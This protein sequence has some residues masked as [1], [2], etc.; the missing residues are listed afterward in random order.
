M[1]GEDKKDLMYMQARKEVL[2][3]ALEW[4]NTRASTFTADRAYAEM[5]LQR[6]VEAY[7]AHGGRG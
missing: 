3:A 2:R 5:R 4:G 7:K 6:A 1:A